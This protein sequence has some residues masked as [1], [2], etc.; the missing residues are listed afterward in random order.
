M[1]CSETVGP[2]SIDIPPTLVL[3]TFLIVCSPGLLYYAC[4][5]G[6][7]I[8]DQI[9]VCI[10]AR[11]SHFPGQRRGGGD[12]AC[13]CQSHIYTIPLQMK[14]IKIFWQYDLQLTVA[15]YVPITLCAHD[16]GFPYSPFL[17]YLQ[18]RTLH[19]FHFRMP[20]GF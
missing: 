5:F 4:V 2:V 17:F 15:V 20:S 3:D 1:W 19:A 10:Q 7:S 18:G 8:V 16:D 12:R 9:C 11:T 13:G 6:T 14:L